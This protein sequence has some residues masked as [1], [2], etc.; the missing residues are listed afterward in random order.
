MLKIWWVFVTVLNDRF[1]F[2]INVIFH[3]I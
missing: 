2:F 1:I 3:S